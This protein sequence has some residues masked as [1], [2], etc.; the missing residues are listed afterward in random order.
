MNKILVIRVNAVLK[1]DDMNNLK[2]YIETQKKDGGI[3]LLPDYCEAIVVP[4]DTDIRYLSYENEEV[5]FRDFLKM[6]EE[7]NK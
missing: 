2:N 6:A 4:E 1:P 5:T 7:A 3:I